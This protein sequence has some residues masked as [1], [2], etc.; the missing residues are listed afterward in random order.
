[1]QRKALQ[2]SFGLLGQPRQSANEDSFLGQ[3]LGNPTPAVHARDGVK[4]ALTAVGKYPFSL[5]T[6]P[7]VPDGLR[8]AQAG[9]QTELAHLQRTGHHVL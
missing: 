7:G 3:G 9:D 8:R 2:L 4:D 6:L 5:F 1:M